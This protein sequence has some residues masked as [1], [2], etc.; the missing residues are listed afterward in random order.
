MTI[1]NY[2][3]RK[4][5]LDFSEDSNGELIDPAAIAWE[6]QLSEGHTIPEGRILA[7][8]EVV[9]DDAIAFENGE[10]LVLKK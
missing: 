3:T 8:G 6:K 5:Q 1:D 10:Y 2:T 9:P 4:L 7:A